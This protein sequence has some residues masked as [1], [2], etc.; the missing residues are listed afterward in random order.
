VNSKNTYTY[1]TQDAYIQDSFPSFIIGDT[2]PQLSIK[3]C[4]ETEGDGTTSD[5]SV[6]L[7]E[8]QSE[9]TVSSDPALWPST[10]KNLQ[11]YWFENGPFVYQNKQC[12]FI[13]SARVYTVGDKNTKTRYLT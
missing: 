2:E 7:S 10:N 3:L 1:N 8:Q 9:N 11:S 5:T 6:N 12:T 13:K 4:G